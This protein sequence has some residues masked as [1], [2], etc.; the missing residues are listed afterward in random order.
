MITCPLNKPNKKMKAYKMA[1]KEKNAA[2]RT[3]ELKEQ[4]LNWAADEALG[5]Y[6]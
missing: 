2:H 5:L 6:L 1:A 4:M 3:E